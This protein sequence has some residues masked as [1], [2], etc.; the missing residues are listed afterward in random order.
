MKLIDQFGKNWHLKL[1]NLPSSIECISL[2]Y[3]ECNTLSHKHVPSRV[4]EEIMKNHLTTIPHPKILW[5]L[6]RV[7]GYET[8]NEK[9]TVLSGEGGWC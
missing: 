6:Q 2:S 1:P 8:G 4:F 3:S 5:I 9:R 7:H